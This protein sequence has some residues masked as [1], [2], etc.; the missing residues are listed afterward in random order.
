MKR[1]LLFFLLNYF[2]SSCQKATENPPISKENIAGAWLLTG[3]RMSATGVPEQD[4]FATMD[5]C[6]KDNLYYFDVNNSLRYLDSGV[7]CEMNQPYLGSWELRDEV[8]EF[9][10]QA[11]NITKFDGTYMEITV[12]ITDAT[13]EIVL[14]IKYTFKRI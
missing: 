2:I 11:G 6:E 3:K 14:T 9:M 8:I 7:T 1:I 13:T 12:G 4:A 10:G 5:E